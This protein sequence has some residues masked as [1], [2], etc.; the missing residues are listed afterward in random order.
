MARAATSVEQV[1][2]EVERAGSRAAAHPWMQ[3]VAR[4]GILSKSAV[5]AVLGTL[6]LMAA[7]GAGGETTDSRGAIAT[8]AH[9]PYG[10][11]MVALLA[12]G[13]LAL[14][15]WF[16]L[17][18]IADREGRSRDWKGLVTRVA[19]G[20]GG[21][22]YLGLAAGAATLAMGGG[23][24][25]SSNAVTRS[26]TARA[27]GLPAGRVLVAIAGV[28][29]LVVAWHQ[30]RNGWRTFRRPETKLATGSMG[31][32]LRA[33]APRLALAGYGTQGLVVGLIGVFLGQ[34]ALL[35]DASEATGFDGALATIARQPYGMALLGA[36]AIGLIAYAANAAIEARCKR[37]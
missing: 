28:I 20:V 37:L 24:G 22:M 27:L 34:A 25:P 36:V 2:R 35:H 4:V 3:L 14:G 19:K 26:Y 7:V 21:L 33:W 5:Y 6:A 18:P 9:Q 10:R 13:F 16:V 17:E 31:P 12:V 8:I 1:G 29:A 30:L 15:A 32:H 11:A 23:A